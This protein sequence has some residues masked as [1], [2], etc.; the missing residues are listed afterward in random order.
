MEA[1]APLEMEATGEWSELFS[2]LTIQAGPAASAKG[3]EIVA[4]LESA[5]IPYVWDPFPP[6]EMAGGQRGPTYMLFTVRVPESQLEDARRAVTD[7]GSPYAGDLVATGE[8]SQVAPF[9]Q[10]AP[11]VDDATALEAAEQAV[12]HMRPE[13]EQTSRAEDEWVVLLGD[14]R[15]DRERFRAIDGALTS[16]GIEH[17]W[18]PYPPQ[19][20]P[21]LRLGIWDTER[22]SVSVFDSELEAARELLASLREDSSSE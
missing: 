17:V 20:A 15:F 6:S 16:A 3:Y 10:Q 7:S 11:A 19:Q 8:P 14:M 22:F 12:Q 9:E 21:L 13:Q 4:P 1:P 5:G 18:E 2:Q